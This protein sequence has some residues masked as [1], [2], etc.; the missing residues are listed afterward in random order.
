[1]PD[2]FDGRR[3]APEDDRSAG[4]PAKRDGRVAR[5]EPRRA[6]ALVGALV[7]LVDD[8]Q[9]DVGHGREDRQPRAGHD[10]DRAGPDAA[11][12]VGPLTDAQARM[13]ER[14]GRVEVR[15]QAVDERQGQGDLRHEDEHGPAGLEA[16]R[17]RLDVDRGLAGAGHAV[18]QDRRGIAIGDR[19]ADRGHRLR[20]CGREGRAG[21]SRA[22]AARRPA[23]QREP[24]ALANLDVDQAPAGEAR[25]RRGSVAVGELR[26]QGDAADRRGEVAQ[27]RHLARPE[28]A[29]S[30]HGRGLAVALRNAR[31]RR[32]AGVVE[33]NPAF[34]ARAAARA[35]ERPVERHEAAAR[36]APKSPQERPST[37]RRSEV[38]HRPR[39]PREVVEQVAFRRLEGG[40]RARR[41]RPRRAAFGDQLQPLEES[42]RQHRPDD[43]GRRGEV[44]RREPARQLEGQGRQQR[45]VGADALGDRLRGNG[46]PL[47][48]RSE[49]DSQRLAPP[50]FDEDRLAR[51]DV[52]QP[53]WQVIGVGPASAAARGV[54]RD[55][56]QPSLVGRG[57]RPGRVAQRAP[58]ASSAGRLPCPSDAHPPAASGGHA[59]P[60]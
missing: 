37:L 22:T 46:R 9:A 60:R 2:R 6:V 8:D 10:V 31:Q 43:D 56:D 39:A 7:L 14:H 5:L 13:H 38:A 35:E 16:G 25:Q 29:G 23:G 47:P 36:Q 27:E 57:L 45:P 4:Q 52:G 40:G 20:L 49:D 53:F 30:G 15:P 58:P 18:E 51:L 48:R 17:D 50:V 1:M 59:R 54:D 26:R 28:G 41:R 21:G 12:F 19:P 44:R 34:E 42:G 11:P 3:G 24:L 55:L 33:A 32:P